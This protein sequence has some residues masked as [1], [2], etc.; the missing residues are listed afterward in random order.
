MVVPVFN[1]PVHGRLPPVLNGREMGEKG[2]KGRIIIPR[3]IQ[4]NRRRPREL[5]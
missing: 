5:P 3:R 1:D 2:K 4:G